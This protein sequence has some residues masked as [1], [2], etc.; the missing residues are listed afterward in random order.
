M[1]RPARPHRRQQLLGALG[2]E[3]ERDPAVR[4]LGGLLHGLRA[5]R[6]EVDRDVGARRVDQELERL[7][8]AGALDRQLELLALVLERALAGERLAHD[9]HVLARARDGPRERHAVPALGDLRARHAQAEPEAPL[10]E[11]VERGRGHGGHRGRAGGD[12]EQAGAEADPLGHRAQVP[13]HGGGVLAP[14]LGHP[15]G[16]EALAV[17]ELRQLDLLL[18]GVPGPVGDVEA[19]PHAAILCGVR[20]A[21]ATAIVALAVAAPAA[22]AWTPDMRSARAYAEQRAG[23]VTFAVR[24]PGRAYGHRAR[25][26]VRSASVVK[27]MLMVAYLNHRTVAGG[28]RC[29]AP[30]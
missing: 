6:A 20:R 8:Q 5:D 21:V 11:G 24:T 9:L 12:L 28:A 14:G 26:P 18:G 2:V 25:T 30:T 3:E 23:N 22:H 7:A 16:V 1:S 4:D 27:A 15:H 29:G 10:G 17:G 13:E 19:D